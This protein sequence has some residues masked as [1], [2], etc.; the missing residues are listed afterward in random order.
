[1]FMGGDERQAHE[2]GMATR[3]AWL[4]YIGGMTQEDIATRLGVSRVKVNRL[5]A[6]AHKE[7]LVRVTIEGSAAH[8]IELEETLSNGYGLEFCV[9]APDIGETDLPLRTLAAAGSH[10]LL[11][12]LE[13]RPRN[14]VGLG[15]G[16]TLGAVIDRLPRMPQCDSKFVSLL[17]SL[18][19][20][21]AA[22]PYDVIHRLA[23]RVPGE[24][25]FMPVPMMANTIDDK[26]VLMAQH[27][28]SQVF[29]TARQAELMIVGIGSVSRTPHLLETGMITS[30][31][32][33]VLEQLG[34]RGEM[35]GRFFGEDG[36]VIE[37]EIADRAMSL[38]LADLRGKEV[39]AIAGGQGKA[40]AIRAVLKSGILSGLITDEST[41]HRMVELGQR[42]P[43]R[44]AV[45]TS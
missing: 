39:V 32:F 12:T 30:G 29:E 35:L 26:A 44:P 42:S 25:F 23:E 38:D 5:I 3:A 34:A 17:G 16:R 7:G 10:F 19:R 20:H 14:I 6:M 13:Q 22:N 1:M 24:T 2:L 40:H 36:K 18:T 8:C 27:S 9:V 45:Q 4:S 28:V 11:T 15:H 43:A 21:A 31:E 33:A 41:A 37:S